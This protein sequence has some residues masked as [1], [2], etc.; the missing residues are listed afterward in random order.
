[1]GVKL[2]STQ[3]VLSSLCTEQELSNAKACD[4]HVLPGLFQFPALEA[5]SSMWGGGS[6]ISP[7]TLVLSGVQWLPITWGQSP[8]PLSSRRPP[9]LL[10]KPGLK[11]LAPSLLEKRPVLTWI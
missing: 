10:P 5:A 6:L 9:Y 11:G 4:F 3:K 7:P 2:D 8:K 1:M